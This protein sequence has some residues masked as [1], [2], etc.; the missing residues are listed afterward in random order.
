[1]ELRMPTHGDGARKPR[2]LGRRGQ[3]VLQ[4][5]PFLLFS[6]IYIDHSQWS[7]SRNLGWASTLYSGDFSVHN[8]HTS[9]ISCAR[10]ANFLAWVNSYYSEG[11]SVERGGVM[12]LAAT[13]G[14]SVGALL[15]GHRQSVRCHVSLLN[16]MVHSSLPSPHGVVELYSIRAGHVPRMQYPRVSNPSNRMRRC[17]ACVRSLT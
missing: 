5:S 1:M 9:L 6:L 15:Y 14:P 11:C 13:L 4:S 12:N 3:T 8:V 7:G 10:A 2:D 16:D 17:S